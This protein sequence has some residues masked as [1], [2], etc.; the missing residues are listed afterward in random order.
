MKKKF[1]SLLL[2]LALVLSL[3]TVAYAEHYDGPE[4]MRAVFTAD[5][6]MQ[7]TFKSNQIS[8]AISELQPGDD[9]TFTVTVRNDY[10]GTVDWYYAN[11][12]VKSLEDEAE[13]AGAKGGGY[14]YK[15]TYS[16]PGGDQTL[17]DSEN[18]GGEDTSGGEG[19][20]QAAG[21]LKD[22]LFLDTFASGEGGTLTLN[23]S[24]DGLAQHNDY[25]DTLAQL[26]LKF[27]VDLRDDQPNERRREIVRTGDE[28]DAGLYAGL[29][30]VS[31]LLVLL[32][33]VYG[34]SL[35]RKNRKKKEEGQK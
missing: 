12:I 31:G 4:G 21:A 17:F 30:A 23:V 24:V 9:A 2:M 32:I 13:N 6:T 1:L 16:G 29:T 28:N 19:L 20:H 34:W 18:L 14:T 26:N 10:P 8:Q 11:D 15:L 25:Q 35:N 7:S 5:K 33:A 27:A 3:G 22:Y